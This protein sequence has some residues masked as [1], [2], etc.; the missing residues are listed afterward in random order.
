MKQGAGMLKDQEKKNQS[1]RFYELKFAS[2]LNELIFAKKQQWAV[3]IA[4]MH[5]AIGYNI[6]NFAQCEPATE[7]CRKDNR[8]FLG[9]SDFANRC[10]VS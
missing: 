10:L 4:V 3:A 9:G 2:N 6:W 7:L 8:K 1:T 5:D